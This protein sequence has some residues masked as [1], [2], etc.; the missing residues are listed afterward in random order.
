[1]TFFE[2]LVEATKKEREEFEGIPFIRQGIIGNL[3]L[4]SYL[5]FLTEAYHHV[6]HTAPLLM[7]AGARIPDRLE[8]LRLDIGE[9]IQEEIGHDEWIL[10]DIKACG[11]DSESVRNG[12]PALATEL[13]VS[14][15]YDTI[16]RKNPL[17]LFGMIFVLEGTSS[18]IATTVAKAIQ[19]RLCL[20][21]EAFTYLTSHGSLD[22]EHIQFFEK[23]MGRLEC[24]EDKAAIIHCAKVMYEL[25]G[26]IF[27]SLPLEVRSPLTFK[28]GASVAC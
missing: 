13:M 27:R 18:Q 17:G 12:Q 4:E 22:K 7:A 19:E 1:M 20:S 28:E 6:K 8:W 25:Y 10:N 21:D 3:P 15:L 9:Y 24:D 11:F 2:E 16:S 26:N 23:I 14:Y 5:A